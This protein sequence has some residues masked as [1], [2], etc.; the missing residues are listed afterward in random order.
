M[1][2]RWGEQEAGIQSTV[3]AHED[4]LKP[5]PLFVASDPSGVGVMH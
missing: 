2:V 3:G 4:R 1:D 5:T